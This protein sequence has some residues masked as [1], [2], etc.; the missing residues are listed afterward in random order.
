MSDHDPA[1]DFIN[2]HQAEIDTRVALFDKVKERCAAANLATSDDINLEDDGPALIVHMAC[3]RGTRE[4]KLEEASQAQSFLDMDFERY[5]FLPGYDAIFCPDTGELEA[6]LRQ[7]GSTLQQ[8]SLVTRA[9]LLGKSETRGRVRMQSLEVTGE[10]STKAILQPE[11]SVLSA[12]LARPSR[13]SLKISQPGLTSA[14]EFEK[15]LV[16]LSNALF[17]QVEHLSGIGLGLVRH[18]PQPA[19]RSKQSRTN[20]AEVIQFPTMEY[21]EAPISL[22]WYGRNASGIPLLQFLAYYQVLEYYYPVYSKAE[23]NRRVRHV[24]KE[25]GFRADRD[26][27]VNRLLGVIQAAR[28]G[29]FFDERAQLSATL[30]ECLDEGEL[31][32]F[33][34]ADEDRKAWF[35]KSE[36]QSVLKVRAIP[37]NDSRADLV[38][39]VAERIYQIRCKIVHTKAEGGAGE[40]ELLLPYSR[41]AES[42]THDIELVRYA[43]QKVLICASVPFQL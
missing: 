25:P 13:V 17:F 42:L 7:L 10:N 11:S 40:V 37:L 15:V 26:A 16:K 3:G 1:E 23:A 20:L 43:C 9:R 2:E 4:V 28:G 32:E 29:G 41:E 27:D 24:L 22:Y 6:L 14:E 35:I 5:R 18:R 12:L 39:E 34:A 38:S 33:F 21:D 30:K 8:V 19:P 31:R 36:K